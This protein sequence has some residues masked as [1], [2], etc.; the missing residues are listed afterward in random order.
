MQMNAMTNENGLAFHCERSG[1][2]VNPST[3]KEF[4]TYTISMEVRY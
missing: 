1:V 2:M 3:R 4:V